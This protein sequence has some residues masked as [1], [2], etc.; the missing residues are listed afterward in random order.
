MCFA[1]K[2]TQPLTYI[3]F[4]VQDIQGN[5]INSYASLNTTADLAWHYTCVDL[6]AAMKTANSA[7]NTPAAQLKLL[8]VCFLSEF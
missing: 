6:Y 5:I 7:F 2:L 8:M 3:Y 4:Q 1:Y